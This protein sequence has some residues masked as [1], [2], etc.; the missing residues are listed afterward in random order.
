MAKV[1]IVQRNKKREKL[2]NKYKDIRAELISIRNSKFVTLEERFEA[3]KKISILPRNSSKCRIRNRCELTG[4]GR[5]FYRMF[6]V[7][8]ICVRELAA[9][10]RLPG[11]T[12][13]SW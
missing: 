8:R 1:S 2:F 11:L 5:G 6:K 4:R 9:Q 7:S 3:Q 12:K 13:A 10:T